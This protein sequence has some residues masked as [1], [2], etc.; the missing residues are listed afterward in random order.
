MSG[1]PTAVRSNTEAAIWERIIRPHGKMT[2]ETAR[3]IVRLEFSEEQG[4]RMHELAAKN[5][6]GTLTPDEQAELD[7]F[8]RVGSLLSILHSRARQALKPRRRAS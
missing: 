8:C 2:R 3:Q 5:R 4:D 7:D 6:A 1:M